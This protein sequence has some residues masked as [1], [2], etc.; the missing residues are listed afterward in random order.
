MAEKKKAMI[1]G[2]K[3]WPTL[4]KR[5]AAGKTQM[6]RIWVEPGSGE[7]GEIHVRHGLEGGAQRH[8]VEKI[9]AGKNLGR[10][11]ETSPFEQAVLEAASRHAV[12]KDRKGYGHTVEESDAAKLLLPMLA[13]TY[14]ERASSVDWETAYVQ[15]KLDGFR[16]RASK[17]GTGKIRLLSREM[18][19]ITTMNHIVA[20][21]KHVMNEGD[22]FDGELYA[23]GMSLNKISSAVKRK[24]KRAGHADEIKF[25]VYDCDTRD[26]FRDRS[27]YVAKALAG[28]FDTLALVPT[29]TIRSR[30]ELSVCEAEYI[31]EGYEG[32]MLRH[33]TKGYQPGIRSEALLKV[34]TFVD[35]EFKVVDVKEGRGENKGMATFICETEDGRV[36]NATSPGTHE[37]KRAYWDNHPQYIGRLLTIK[38]QKMTAT[39]TPVPFLPTAKGFFADDEKD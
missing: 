29:V 30:D 9:T 27:A 39:K 26:K 12:K 37:E 18:Q 1:K 10:S 20:E 36:F 15:P 17:D 38:Y 34:K 6:W 22:V 28:K 33:G 35:G 8:T 16:C 13:Q 3:T 2:K 5:T 32:V 4:Y 19:P 25:N 23:H 14:E 21:L 11:N 24:S 7:I 31:A